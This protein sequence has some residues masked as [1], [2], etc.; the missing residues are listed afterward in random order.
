MS[1]SG[2]ILLVEDDEFVAMCS[3]A[4]WYVRAIAYELPLMGDRHS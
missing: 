4:Y 3:G 1:T 2:D